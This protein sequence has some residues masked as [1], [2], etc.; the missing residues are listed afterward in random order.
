MTNQTFPV[1]GMTCASCVRRVEKALMSVPGV[2]SVHVDLAREEASITHA[3]VAATALAKAVEGRGYGLLLDPTGRDE[4]ADVRRSLI[5]VAAALALS[6]PLLLPMVG[7]PIHVRWEIQALLAGLAAFVCGSG[8]FIRA[9]KLARHGEASMD[10]LVAIGSLAAFVSGVVEGISGAHHTSFEIAATLPALVL[11]GKHLESRA[12]HR[13]TESLNALLEL[14]P[15][16]AT[17]IV[18]ATEEEVPVDQLRSGDRVRVRPGGRIPVD[19]V[20]RSGIAAVEEAL[21]TGEPLPVSKSP[22]DSVLAGAVVHGGSLDIEV[23]A[24]GTGTWLARLANQVAE[25]KASRPPVQA[26]ADRLSA[27][28]VPVVI[29]LSLATF[30]GWWLATG[31]LAIAWRPAVT[32]LVIACPC[33]LGLAT[34]V[35]VATALGTAAR[36]GLLVRD[37]AALEQLAAATDL[38]L[39]KTGTLTEGRPQ[40]REVRVVAEVGETELRRLAAALER[41][42]EHPL[43]KAL[44]SASPGELP[45]VSNFEAHVGGGVSGRIGE[46]DLRLGNSAFVGASF[47]GVPDDMIAVGLADR[48]RLLG[49]FLL[50]DPMRR[51]TPDAVAQLKRD[52]LRLHVLSGDRQSTV[53]RFAA[54]VGIDQA[55]GGLAPGEKAAHIRA[56]QAEGR[57]VAFTGDGINDA[58]ALATADAGI[59]LPGLDATAAS[60]GLNLRREGLAP[61]LDARRLA[62][63]L[64]VIVRQNLTW[65]FAYNLILVP[66]AA[67]GLLERFGGPLLAGAAMGL[68]SVTVVVNALR[69]R[70]L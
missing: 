34:P 23:I 30:A 13:A 45:A 31:D 53:S 62:K 39:D 46:R 37:L 47:D 8:F 2:E 42:S 15:A 35:A 54:S 55:V 12:K 63:K 29:L 64:H 26:L 3:G 61:L 67:S 11:L 41:D 22:G 28:F 25:A 9:G 58:A 52:G 43:A 60:A 69:L 66:L 57:V 5:R 21:L 16:T 44:R 33:A 56:L 59:S 19:G 49:I 27:I 68:S 17:R 51:E 38:V 36:Q 7:V 50:G 14:A 4:A 6:I 24:A 32:L 70:R 40:V 10:T 65:A 48:G 18:E 20:V 1:T